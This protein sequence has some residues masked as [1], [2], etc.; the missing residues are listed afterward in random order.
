VGTVGQPDSFEAFVGAVTP[1][2]RRSANVLTG[3]ASLAEDLV[4]TVLM[5]VFVRWGR[6]GR[7]DSP[8]AYAQRILYTTFYA[9]SG[10]R[11]NLEVPT[12]QL[13][14]QARP[15][16]LGDS[17]TGRVHTALMSLPRRQRAVLVARFYDDLSVEQTAD[18]LGT[19][20]SNVKS[21]TARGL[22]KLREALPSSESLK[23]DR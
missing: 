7:W 11:W 22:A 20:P 12:G 21:H 18:L 14:E 23:E 17:D 13:P 8:P 1:R 4:Q 19:S 3:D 16:A 6:S 5:K 9:W 15:D 2:L 10:R